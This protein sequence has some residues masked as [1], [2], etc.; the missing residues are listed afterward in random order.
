MQFFIDVSNN[1]FLLLEHCY[2]T[3]KVK[4]LT[5]VL[6]FLNT[7]LLQPVPCRVSV[8]PK[9]ILLL[10][11]MFN[12]RGVDGNNRWQYSQIFSPIN[13]YFSFQFLLP[14][15]VVKQEVDSA[16]ENEFPMSPMI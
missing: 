6:I 14:R 9:Y 13:N 12:G 15:P 4:G 16:V 7:G 8:F 1:L 11:S 5:A 2:L 10:S 3:L